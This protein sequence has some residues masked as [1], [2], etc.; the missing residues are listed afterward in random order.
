MIWWITSIFLIENPYIISNMIGTFLWLYYCPIPLAKTGI[1]WK[2]KQQTNKY[3]YSLPRNIIYRYQLLNHQTQDHHGWTKKK[4]KN[5]ASTHKN[6]YKRYNL[7]ESLKTSLN[8]KPNSVF[9]WSLEFIIYQ[10]ENVFLLSYKYEATLFLVVQYKVRLL[11]YALI[12]Y[13]QK[14]QAIIEDSSAVCS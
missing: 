13:S 10:C 9:S 7:D 1:V 11:L 8:I 6:A 4:K 12:I 14:L 5:F 2:W 3:N